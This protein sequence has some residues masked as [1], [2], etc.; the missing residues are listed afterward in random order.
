MNP[1]DEERLDTGDEGFL[2]RLHR[3]KLAARRGEALSEEPVLPQAGTA[4]AEGPDPVEAAPPLT[5]ADMPPVDSLDADSD[6]SGFLSPGVS[7]ALQR[8]ALRRLWQVADME[9]ID[10][11][12]IYAS[13]YR[14]FEP[15]GEIVT[16]EMRHRMELEARR[17]AEAALQAGETP[18]SAVVG[19][20]AGEQIPLNLDA[21]TPDPDWVGGIPT[22]DHHLS[23]EDA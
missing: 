20:N 17:R 1:T 14:S 7:E 13:D 21:A 8:A 3:R 4:E 11:L 10:D 23:E 22:V 9:F 15:L 2:Q 16:Q 5:D 19:T 18:D 6:F 12:D